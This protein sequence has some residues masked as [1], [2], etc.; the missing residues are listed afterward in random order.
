MCSSATI[1]THTWL[2]S[3]FSCLKFTTV[4]SGLTMIAF[5]DLANSIT[6]FWVAGIDQTSIQMLLTKMALS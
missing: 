5:S 2:P 6:E 1:P 4:P 3:H